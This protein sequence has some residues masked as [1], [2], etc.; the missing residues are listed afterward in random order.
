VTEII[1]TIELNHTTKKISVI[2]LIH[3]KTKAKPKT[4]HLKTVKKEGFTFSTA[5][6][7]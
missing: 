7:R 3:Q 5:Q 4:K 6:R 2:V 1:F